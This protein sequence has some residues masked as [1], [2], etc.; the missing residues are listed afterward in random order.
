MTDPIDKSEFAIHNRMEIVF[1]LNDLAKGRIAINLDG[2]QG[3]S[4]LTT[5]LSVNSDQNQLL[6]D[7][8]R[9]DNLNERIVNSKRVHFYTSTG[10]KVRWYSTGLRVIARSDG[11]VF[12]M[13]VPPVIERVQRRQH[14]RLN[15]PQGR[16]ALICKIPLRNEE[17]DENEDA[18]EF[19]EATIMD[20]SAGGICISF[21]GN[22]PDNFS[23]GVEISGCSFE[24][25]D[26]GR[27][28][29]NLRI[30]RAW[31]HKTHSGEEMHKVGMEF[32]NLSRGA[33][34]V[35]QRYMI[36]LEKNQLSVAGG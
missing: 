36:E 31:H 23:Q 29:I 5:I 21:K 3:A 34:N 35:I 11:N 33:S 9:D 1:T 15:T 13:P 16:H 14:F 18:M 22:L 28:P 8:S 10:V 27:I 32:I 24:L 12:A 6:V 25:P 20:M 30:C 19:L 17:D 2:N 26:V 4:L 7:C